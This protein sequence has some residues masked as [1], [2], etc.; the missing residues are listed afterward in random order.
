[1]NE[2]QTE[3]ETALAT[4]RHALERFNAGRWWTRSAAGLV[5][6]RGGES[7]SSRVRS[8]NGGTGSFRPTSPSTTGCGMT[9]S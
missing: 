9:Q 1:V 3:F 6:R 8:P 2:T 7:G 4:A 5:Y